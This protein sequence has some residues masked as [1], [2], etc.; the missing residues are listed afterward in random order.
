M[1]SKTAFGITFPLITTST[2]AKMGKTA[3]GA[4]WLDGQRTS[5]YEYFQFWIN[6]DD[7]DVAR[8]TAL[9][10]FLPMQEID[11]IAD[12]E[13]AGLNS[14]KTILAYEATRLAHGKA[15]A[16]KAHQAAA[17]MFGARN[18]EAT[19]LP[20]SEIKRS[21]ADTED[22]SVP[23]SVMEKSALVDGI[24]AFKLFHMVGLANSGGAARRLITQGGGYLNGERLDSFDRMV[25][26]SD[27][28]EMEIL[29]RSGKKRFHKI[30]IKK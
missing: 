2:G 18:I 11:Q 26:D 12:L 25:T 28:K 21:L 17:A 4:V 16:D 9:F 24:P 14:A 30:K 27:I 6:T 29:L 13:G 15:A 5:P 22:D 1:R 19:I 20:S 10:T 23:S 8:F 3:K 7:R